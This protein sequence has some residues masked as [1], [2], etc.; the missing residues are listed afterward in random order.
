MGCC[1]QGINIG[2]VP[3]RLLLKS[4]GS[5]TLVRPANLDLCIIRVLLCDGILSADGA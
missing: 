5:E 2:F 1:H 3:T 4:S